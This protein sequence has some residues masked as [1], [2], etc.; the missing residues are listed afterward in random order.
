VTISSRQIAGAD[1]VNN[2][3][4]GDSGDLEFYAPEINFNSGTQVLAHA[5]DG[6][7]GG[8]ISALAELSV[9]DAVDAVD[10]GVVADDSLFKAAA[11]DFQAVASNDVSGLAGDSITS[12]VNALIDLQNSTLDTESGDVFLSAVATLSSMLSLD[13]I[14][15]EIFIEQAVSAAI[16]LGAGT[17]V[18][19]ASVEV[20]TETRNSV[21]AA[22]SNS[23]NAAYSDVSGLFSALASDS[24]VEVASGADIQTTDPGN[25]VL[26]ARAD[27]DVDIAL[28][29]VKPDA[30]SPSAV[31]A[32]S[33]VDS[34]AEATV[35]ADLDV[36]ILEVYAHSEINSDVS[37]TT[38]FPVSVMALLAADEL[39]PADLPLTLTVAASQ[40]NNRAKA[41]FID[42]AVIN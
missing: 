38:V 6:Y 7:N 35:A 37:A 39:D 21:S 20:L 34:N 19:G 24:R 4:T 27:T 3:S 14:P 11:I 33:E 13:N 2:A 16:F 31:M 23:A 29:H 28:E 41:G 32:V 18:T 15:D 22:L 9:L 17:V 1:H 36:S 42:G 5:T 40:H 26:S 10:V 25:V 30:E 12:E 8:K